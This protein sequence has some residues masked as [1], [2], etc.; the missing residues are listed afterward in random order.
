MGGGLL[1]PLIKV[2]YSFEFNIEH[3]FKFTSHLEVR[4]NPLLFPF[5]Q[6]SHSVAYIPPS[7]P[8]PIAK[9]LVHHCNVGY[10]RISYYKIMAWLNRN[11]NKCSQPHK[12]LTP[13]HPT[14]LLPPIQMEISARLGSLQVATSF[15]HITA[16]FLEETN[17]LISSCLVLGFR[18]HCSL[19]ILVHIIFSINLIFLSFY[20]FTIF[21][22]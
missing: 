2:I 6:D 14:F 7:M 12:F 4:K 10:C 13:N 16:M 17:L 18:S 9:V 8:F 15:H 22:S 5:T 1:N 19:T 3:H 21:L 11:T 20:L